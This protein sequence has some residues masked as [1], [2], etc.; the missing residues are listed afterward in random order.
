MSIAADT[1]VTAAPRAHRLLRLPSAEGLFS[2]GVLVLVG[3]LVGI[4][5]LAVLVMSLRQGLPGQARPLTL[6]NFAEVFSDPFTAH[7]M[8]NT[9]AFAAAAIGV[10]LLF[11]VPLV[12]L[13]TRTDLPGKETIYVLMTIGILIPVFLRVIGWILLFSPQIG[14]VNQALMAALGLSEPPLNLYNVIG[15]AV[16]QGVSFVPAAFFM[17]VAAYRAIDPALEEAAYTSGASRLQTVLRVNLP[18]TLP[19]ILGVTVYLLMTAISVFETPALL[20]L[21]SRTFV[22]SS[23]IYFAV[24][25]QTGLPK[26]GLA[27]TYG[28]I[29][30]AL[31]LLASY[32]Y[33][34]VVSESKKYAVISGKGYRP[35]LLELGRWKWL[36]LGFVAFYF[37]LEIF[38][39]LAA[40]LWASLLPYLQVPSPAALREVSLNNYL[41][42]PNYVSWTPILNTIILV[43]A[44][45]TLTMLLS[46]ACSWVVVRSRSAVRGPLDTLAFL[47]HA[48][49]SIVFAV[50]LAW[51]ALS[52]RSWLP[53]YGSIVIIILAH[54][55]SHLAYGT[56]TM[57]STM[58]QVHSELE[59]A[60]RLS[61]A[62][63]LQV[64]YRILLPLVSPAIFNAWLWLALLSSREVTMALVLYAPSTEVLTTLVWKMWGSSWIGP[65][66][67]LGVILIAVVTAIVFVLRSMFTRF[68]RGAALSG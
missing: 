4:P 27:A 41:A 54:T 61:G 14:I 49:P 35:R 57:N 66:S 50:A 5:T 2:A 39:P 22:L 24:T 21:P 12:W 37:A 6:A 56:R 23:A 44:A 67:A 32:L 19:A 3:V 29:M 1:R 17:I 10:T 46:L 28:L 47:P 64:F 62:N 8:G 68:Y 36:G 13:V 30:M 51:L 42:L 9:L 58:I 45:P 63:A 48:I 53:I 55:I 25:P 26:Y 33:F 38:L 43:L 15:M 20:G 31:G 59:E 18:L 60:G 52:Y 16:T 7:V 11:A 65:V 34:R 40:L